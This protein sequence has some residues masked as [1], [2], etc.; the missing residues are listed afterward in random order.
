MN[1][2]TLILAAGAVLTIANVV[3]P[4][5]FAPPPTKAW[6]A[7]WAANGPGG[8]LE[9]ITHWR[10]A[11]EARERRDHEARIFFRPPTCARYTAYLRRP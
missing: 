11:C 8:S 4:R 10:E 3:G 2:L 6:L 9:E 1:R 5:Y 7:Y